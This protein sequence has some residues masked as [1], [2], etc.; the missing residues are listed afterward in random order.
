MGA[1]D[2]SPATA[3]RRAEIFRQMSSAEKSAM[4]EEMSEDA[5]DVARCGIRSRHLEYAPDE[6]EQALHRLLVGDA[7]AD[8]AWPDFMHLRP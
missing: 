2:T 7:L 4:V 3:W 1:S 5:R 8:R 6:V